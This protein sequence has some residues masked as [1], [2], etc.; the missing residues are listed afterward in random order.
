MSMYG[1]DGVNQHERGNS[2]FFLGRAGERRR[3]GEGMRGTCGRGKRGM[4]D[5]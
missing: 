4:M 1:K 5:E 3:V 2:R